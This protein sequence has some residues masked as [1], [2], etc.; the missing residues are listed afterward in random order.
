M[1]PIKNKKLLNILLFLSNILLAILIIKE[2]KILDFCHTII[3][4]L[5]PLFW[6]YSIAWLIKPIML[7]FNNYFK[8][9]LSTIITYSLLVLLLVVI[10]YL[11]V[12]VI[13]NEVKILIPHI[14]NIYKN[15]DPLIL[16]KIDV[17]LLSTKILTVLNK[18]TM[19][20]K[21][22]ILTIFYSIFISFFFLTNH[23]SVSNFF[24][25]K[26]PTQL[27]N[28]LSINLKAFVKGTLL[29]TFI[30]FFLSIISFWIAKLPYALLF[31]IIISLT[32]IIPYLGPYIG[33]V[34]SVI[35]A[36]NVSSEL[37]MIILFIV[38]GLQIIESAFVHPYVMSKS[39]KVN[40]IFIMISLIVF[41][42]FFG[43]FGMILSTP[44]VSIIK[45]LYLYNKEHKIINWQFLDR[46]FY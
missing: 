21:D 10:G 29:V 45:T 3:T 15:L 33:G 28:Q 42:Y 8:T 14:M 19:N 22:S 4:L 11:A 27:I 38:V 26:V 13:I 39:V 31:A 44:I 24:A 36:F 18:Y 12:P 43:I 34:P 37:G 1:K 9:I 2:F 16:S 7:Y 6:G 41:G 32:N 46:S 5:A 20:I 17:S 25:K 40:P 30:L 23:R 35:V